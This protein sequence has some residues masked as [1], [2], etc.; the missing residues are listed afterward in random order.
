MD[1]WNPSTCLGQDDLSAYGVH[2]SQEVTAM[3]MTLL[4]GGGYI[5]AVAGVWLRLR[6]KLK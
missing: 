2:T 4:C 6:S 1:A 3:S 5:V